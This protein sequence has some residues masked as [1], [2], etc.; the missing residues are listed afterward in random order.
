VRLNRS[1]AN[2]APQ[3]RFPRQDGSPTPLALHYGRE[4]GFDPYTVPALSD[5]FAFVTAYAG[6]PGR[7][8]G[9]TDPQRRRASRV[10]FDLEL[11][12]VPFHP[13]TIGDRFDGL[14]PALLEERVVEAVHAAGVLNRTG[15]RSFDHRCVKAILQL[16]PGL[17]GGVLLAYTACVDP[18]AL[19]AGVG[20]R[21]FCPAYEYLA[22]DSIPR[23]HQAGI[24]VLPWTVN[25]PDHWVRLFDAGVDGITTDEPDRLRVW[26]EK[27]G[28]G[29]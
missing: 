28:F 22:L 26:L 15:V 1:V 20:A 29:W 3:Q 12:R 17:T 7:Q 18:V 16:E 24:R 25:E 8:A 19:T 13:E 11:K 10:R 4:H 6:E 21:D 23:L 2:P 27:R 5:L 14:R 9:K